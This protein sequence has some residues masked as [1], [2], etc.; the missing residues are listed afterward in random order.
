M[1]VKVASLGDNI[2]VSQQSIHVYMQIHSFTSQVL[3]HSQNHN[4]PSCP[5]AYICM[6]IS[7]VLHHKQNKNITSV[8]NISQEEILLAHKAHLLKYVDATASYR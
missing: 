1:H 5:H 7:L 8:R 2:Y 3:R 6:F 4:H